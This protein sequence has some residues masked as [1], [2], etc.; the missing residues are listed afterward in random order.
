MKLMYLNRSHRKLEWEH[1]VKLQKYWI[2]HNFFNFDHNIGMLHLKTIVL[3]RWIQLNKNFCNISYPSTNKCKRCDTMLISIL[4]DF[5]LLLQLQR[6]PLL[7][8]KPTV[9]L[10]GSSEAKSGEAIKKH[11]LG[12]KSV[13]YVA[14]F[15][16][17]SLV[18]RL[19]NY[20]VDFKTVNNL[21]LRLSITFC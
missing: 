20:T 11:F 15:K 21:L 5:M 9:S 13:R 14:F 3:M 1:V 4:V 12:S 6:S 17:P 19:Q 8:K 18:R 16:L 2:T 10:S 7:G